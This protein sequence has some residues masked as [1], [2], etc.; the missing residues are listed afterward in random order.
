MTPTDRVNSD[1]QRRFASVEAFC[2]ME[3]SEDPDKKHNDDLTFR[4][5]TIP[6]PIAKGVT[7]EVRFECYIGPKSKQ[8]FE[9]VE[10]YKAHNYYEVIK[11]SF[12]W[13]APSALVG[14]MMTLLNVFHK[15][16]PHNYGLAIIVLVV[17]VRGIL[18]PVTK[19]SQVNMMKM[20]TQQARLKPKLDQIREKYANDRTKLNQAM[21]EVYRQ[22]G[23][24]PAGNVLACLPMMLQM[25]IWIA[26]WTAL[27]STID[28]R[29]A[30]FDGWWI[31]DLA[32]P[33]ALYRFS[34]PVTLP[35]V[36][37][38]MGG[39]FETLNLL[40]VL[41]GISQ[42]LQTKFMPRSQAPKPKSGDAPDQMDQQRKMMMIMSVLFVFL[43]YNAPSGLN[44]YIMV[45]NLFGMLEQWRIRQHLASVDEQKEEEER[46][47]KA[48]L[49]AGK[50]TWL[51][52][53]WDELAKEAEETRKL[54]SDRKKDDKKRK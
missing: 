41:L 17:V 15:I 2:Q 36:S 27:A 45:S 9:Q 30:P 3:Q 43:L 49:K 6:T 19:K 52:R 8:A 29:H 1:D 7:R 38:L 37:Y 20:Q 12:R 11:A 5:I 50:K 44:L 34:K 10:A 54:T 40:P 16:P 39:P 48:A 13:C 18:H 42:L 53:K 35:L 46:R 31:R 32:G 21:M 25:P 33:D 24:N 28:M 4:Y 23:I 26:L 22:E 47:R 51:Q 14:L